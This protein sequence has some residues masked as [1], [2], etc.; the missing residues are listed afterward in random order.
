MVILL[1]F[2]LF[3]TSISVCLGEEDATMIQEVRAAAIRGGLAG[4][5]LGVLFGYMIDVVPSI[6]HRV[7]I[8]RVQRGKNNDPSA[9][10]AC[11]VI[12]ACWGAL[13]TVSLKLISK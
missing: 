1:L 6:R 7:E 10:C 12:G 4:A 3:F 5:G 2:F 8:A 9:I 13:A 11:M